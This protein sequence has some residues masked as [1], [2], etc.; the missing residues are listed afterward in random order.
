[1]RLKT[2]VYGTTA[3]DAHHYNNYSGLSIVL[4]A[5]L[6]GFYPKWHTNG[7]IKHSLVPHSYIKLLDSF[8]L[9]NAAKSPDL[10]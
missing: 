9:P 2:H 6:H 8:L 7:C 4:E 1:V 5:L 3:L 10:I